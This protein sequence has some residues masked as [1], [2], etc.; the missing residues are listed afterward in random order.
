MYYSFG[1]IHLPHT[2]SESTQ[3][4]TPCQ[5]SQRGMRL[6]VNWVNA[7]WESMSKESTQKAPTF[8]KISSYRIDSVDVVS[9]LASI[10]LTGNETPCQ[11]S[12]CRMLKIWIIWWIQ[13]QNKTPKRFIIWPLLFDQCKKPEQKIGVCSPD[14]RLDTVLPSAQIDVWRILILSIPLVYDGN[15]FLRFLY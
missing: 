9:H 11:L 13:E 15:R 7:E 4:E 12:H 14:L 5:L 1:L 8:T 10:Q 2:E 6:H 3:S